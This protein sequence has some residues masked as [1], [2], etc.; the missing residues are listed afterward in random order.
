VLL[1]S[2]HSPWPALRTGLGGTIVDVFSQCLGLS[3]PG[4]RQ[5]LKRIEH[6]ERAHA[7]EQGTLRD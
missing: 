5:L 7:P 6:K 4:I 3:A 1:Q 2:Q